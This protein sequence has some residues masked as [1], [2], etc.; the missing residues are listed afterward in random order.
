M[1]PVILDILYKID[2]ITGYIM[3]LQILYIDININ[4]YISVTHHL[5]THY[6]CM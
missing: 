2:E 5:F 4:S 6:W 3:I 1:F